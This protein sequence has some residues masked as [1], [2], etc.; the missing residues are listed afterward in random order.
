MPVGKLDGFGERS[1]TNLQEAIEK[2][3]SQP[4]HRLIYALGIRYVGETTAKTLAHAVETLSDLAGFTEAQLME[5]EDVGEKVA[6]SVSVF[7]HNTDNLHLLKQLEKGG[8]QM[9]NEKKGLVTGGNLS[10]QTFLFTGSL[11]QLKRSEAEERVEANG[12]KIAGSV[13]SKLNYLVVGADAGNKLE[14]AKKIPGIRIIS[15]EEF[16][17]MLPT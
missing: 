2:S 10:G 17:K 13:S 12:G 11:I 14:K 4:L 9:K 1:V 3:K 5:L 7:F 6:G 15:E 8:V 16:L